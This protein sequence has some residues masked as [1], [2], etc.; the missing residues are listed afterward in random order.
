MR[1]ILVLNMINS[2]PFGYRF[3]QKLLFFLSLSLHAR[4]EIR[5]GLLTLLVLRDTTVA[6][7]MRNLAQISNRQREAEIEILQ[8]MK[9]SID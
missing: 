9:G 8:K 3:F 1:N 7:S 2:L 5:T 4:F 6:Q